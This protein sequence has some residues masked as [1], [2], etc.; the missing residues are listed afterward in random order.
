MKKILTTSIEAIHIS[1]GSKS[2]MIWNLLEGHSPRECID[3]L[4]AEFCKNATAQEEIYIDAF[5]EA[6]QKHRDNDPDRSWSALAHNAE[7][8]LT[9]GPEL[10]PHL[11]EWLNRIP[12]VVLAKNGTKAVGE[13]CARER[14]AQCSFC[15]RGVKL[16]GKAKRPVCTHHCDSR[17]AETRRLFR[18]RSEINS[19]RC[20]LQNQ[21]SEEMSALRRAGATD[22]TLETWLER[23]VS[24]LPNLGKLLKMNFSPENAWGR[25]EGKGPY[26]WTSLPYSALTYEAIFRV[27]GQ[28]PHGGYRTK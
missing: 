20:T 28:H 22:I 18:L 19:V 12:N 5:R 8:F 6:L 14:Y 4:V 25:L 2:S 3:I 1:S 15:W 10:S 24:M 17:A 13:F 21:M 11:L 9:N 27:D 23:A 16:E 26:D 7:D